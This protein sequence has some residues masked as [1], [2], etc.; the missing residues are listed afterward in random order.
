MK[1]GEISNVVETDFGY[2][3]IRSMPCAAATRSRSTPCAPRSRT[4]SRSSWRRSG[5]PRSP[6][7]S[8]N[9][10]YEQADSL[11][12][13][14][15]KLKLEKQH[16][17]RAAHAGSRRHGRAG[18]GQAARRRCSATTRCRTS[19]TPKPSR[20]APTSWP[21]RAWCST[22][23][24]ARRPLAE[25][26]RAGAPARGRRASR[27]RGAQGRRGQAGRVARRRR[28]IGTA[29]RRGVV[30]RQRAEPAARPWSTRCCAPMPRKLPAWL[31]VDLGE[32]G[33]A[34]VRVDGDQAAARPTPRN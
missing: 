22:R 30:A 14:V 17:H 3:I 2:H 18:V 5:T 19:A 6:S 32:A 25:V 34:V 31:G 24:R 11:K 13:V 10:V 15:D 4:R 28:R 16:R 12:P 23:R 21:R 9:I 29:R 33:Y 7:S 1:P 20:S 26:Q 27:G 8:R